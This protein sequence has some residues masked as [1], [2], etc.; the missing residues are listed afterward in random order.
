MRSRLLN[1]ARTENV[2]AQAQAAK[3][4]DFA[5]RT[6]L[7]NEAVPRCYLEL[8]AA[9]RTAVL[10][11]NASLVQLPELPLTRLTWYE[12]PNIALHDAFGGDGMRV[13]VGRQKS[14]FDLLLRMISR[15]GKPDIPIIEG[16]GSIGREPIRTETMLRIEGWVENGQVTY[17]VSLN[18]KRMAIPVNEL[19][20]RI[21]MAVAAQD[22]KL[23]WRNYDPAP[24]RE[25]SDDDS[26]AGL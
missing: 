4:N 10:Q 8:V 26:E 11:Y 21:A 1:L 23:L 5:K 14:Y 15:T 12:T 19:P 6:E 13:R 17:W 18:F 25:S 24:P 2:N 20:D 3:I 9:L 22:H 7:L 16:F